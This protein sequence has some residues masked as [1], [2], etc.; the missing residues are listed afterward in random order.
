MKKAISKQSDTTLNADEILKLEQDFIDDYCKNKNSKPL[1]IL[2]SLFNGYY[3]KMLLAVMFCTIKMLPT[4]FIPIAISNI[5]DIVATSPEDCVRRIM[6]NFSV[7]TGLLLLNYPFHML[8]TKYLYTVYRLV[9]AGL[10]GAIMRKLQVLT[11][12]FTKEFQSGRIQ[13]KILRDVESV[14]T[15]CSQT[16]TVFMEAGVRIFVMIMV[17]AYKRQWQIMIFFL[18]SLPI[19]F[20]IRALFK[21]KIAK[22]NSEY[23]KTL[24]YTSSKVVDSI[25]M[26]PIT[27]AHA[28]EE[29]ET[30][31]LANALSSNAK[32]GYSLDKVQMSFGSINWITFNFFRVLCLV[33]SAFLALAKKIT[34]GDVNL[35]NSYFT[36]II[37]LITQVVNLI[38]VISKGSD[39]IISIGE[40][41]SSDDIEKTEN[42]QKIDWLKG[43]FEF[44][45]VYFGYEKDKPVLK[46]LNLKVNAGETIAIVG[47]SGSGKSTILN[48]VTGF[49]FVDG[50]ELLIDGKNIKDIDLKSYRKKIAIVPQSSVMFTG[51]IRDNITYS[52]EN[53]SDERLSEVIK[54]ACLDSVI[55]KLPNGVDTYIGEKGSNLSGGQRQRISIARAI[56]RDPQ[57]IILDEAT[58]ALDTVSEKEIQQAIN[59]LT[60]GK[61]TFIV[62]HRLSTIRDADHIAVMENGRCVEFGTYDELIDKK[63]KFYN[64]RKLQI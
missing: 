16:I 10:R 57:I 54:A 3:G 29:K 4:I 60:V 6:M 7:A 19:V 53:V 36:E 55:E 62:A 32:T 8:Y 24:E 15:L 37:S 42:K 59:N 22:N 26:M 34:I 25:E 30:T 64:F 46:G 47:E 20:L 43:G 63:G 17:I 38:P 35:Y 9:E 13:S 27:R 39:A 58:S 56:I 1:K 33:F 49:Y 23:R 61:T 45:N 5:I 12:K 40:I 41:L 52:A 18:V 50:G 14:I 21:K 51:T 28:V 48:L 31:D 11:V 44:R 2:F